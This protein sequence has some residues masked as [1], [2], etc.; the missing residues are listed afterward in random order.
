VT[1][2]TSLP[3]SPTRTVLPPLT[4]TVEASAPGAARRA[5]AAMNAPVDAAFFGA[6]FSISLA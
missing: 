3:V 4:D 5:S 2:F 1:L 6:P